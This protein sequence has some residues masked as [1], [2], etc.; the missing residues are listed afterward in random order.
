VYFSGRNEL[1]VIDLKSFKSDTIVNDEFWALYPT[2][3]YFSPDDKF[4]VYTAYR[5]FEQDIF[6]YDF[7]KK[8]AQQ[9][10]KTG[11][12]ETDPFWSPDGKYIYFVTDR[13]KA[14]Y[15]WGVDNSNIFRV[16]LTKL[17][18]EF[19]IDRF[20]K[21][22]EKDA[23]KDSSKPSVKI[24]YTDLNDRWEEIINKPS[25][26]SSPFVI[27]KDDETTLLYIS[28]HDGEKTALWKTVITPFDE[29]KTQKISGVTSGGYQISFAKDKYYVL[30]G[31]DIY[32]LKLGENKAEKISVSNQFV[33]NLSDEFGQMF[34][35][36]WANLQENYYDENFH[37]VDWNAMKKRYEKY[38]PF[39]SSR[40][41]LRILLS[42]MLGELNSS[43]LGFN[44]NGDEEK[45]FYNNRTIAFGIVFDNDAP[46]KVDHI[47][48]NSPLDKIDKD[49]KPG[50]VLI[51][52]NGTMIDKSANREFYFTGPFRDEEV[53]LTFERSGKQFD[54]KVHPISRA[55][56]EGLLYDEWVEG[57][58][59][60]VD[61]KSNK[62]IA[63]IHMKNMGEGELNNFIIEMTNEAA[64]RDGLILDIRYNRGGNV[65][66]NV[67]QFLSQ[68]PY[69]Q[70]KYRGGKLTQ[71]PNFTPAAKPI[72]LLVNAQS[73]SDAEMT[74][75]GFKQ[76]GLGKIIGT[77]TYRWI[78]FTSGK[79]LVDGSF[80]RL[81]SWGCYTLDG[82]DLEKNGVAPDIY[83]DTN[84][85]DRLENKDPQLDKAVDEIMKELK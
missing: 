11:V 76:L 24:D 17:D 3:A 51:A 61:E 23:K 6:V 45:S 53:T 28:N 81:P 4:L 72:V 69:L 22:F 10:T 30:A 36:T 37:G 27:Q 39:I 7:D 52:M 19:K 46:Y 83:V 59:K 33:K 55:D 67:L 80:Y 47:V 5:N 26:Q 62:R 34:A 70:W 57:N 1:R 9:I 8:E 54:V 60:Y 74:S 48:K 66:D 43:H 75:Q 85:K 79:S 44:S 50:D 13:F 15:P 20:N 21:L 25:N 82:K 56:F 71:Q 40:E 16:A 68:K 78:I 41:D 84:M 65:H 18:K 14:S 12:T 73:L 29:P 42:D 2:A 58:Q 64:Y 31:G 32:E 38:L 35:E 49:V 63:Y 77:E